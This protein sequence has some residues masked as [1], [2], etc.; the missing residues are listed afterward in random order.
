MA[1]GGSFGW[2]NSIMIPIRQSEAQTH[3]SI[4][5]EEKLPFPSDSPNPV[6][7]L[8]V[9]SLPYTKSCYINLKF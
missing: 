1:K 2:K 8:A 6:S 7:R 5:M 9:L 4:L 3:I